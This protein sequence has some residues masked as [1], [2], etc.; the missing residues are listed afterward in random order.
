VKHADIYCL[1]LPS[2]IETVVIVA[3]ELNRVA[4]GDSKRGILI[5]VI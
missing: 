5:F 1:R 2:N 4:G 3:C